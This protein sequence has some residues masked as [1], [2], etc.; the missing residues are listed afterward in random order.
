[1]PR[2]TQ[3]E[4]TRRR[5][6][7]AK[8]KPASF[9][10]ATKRNGKACK[11]EAG[12]GTDHVGR[13]RCKHHTGSTNVGRRV[14]KQLELVDMATPIKNITPG[15]AIHGVLALAAGQL[16]YAT[17]KVAGLDE[18]E[19]VAMGAF[20]PYKNIWL[21]IQRTCMH[22]LA[23]YAKKAADM[24]LAERQGALAEAQTELVGKMLEAVVQELDLSPKQ[25]K[26]LG[27]AL[28]RAQLT[29]VEG[30]KAA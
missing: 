16:A 23:D 18:D 17:Q 27:P 14:A 24:G 2:S 7:E 30:G 13:G 20:G 12:W 8:Q 21:D 26:A 19:L 3:R 1:M 10:G 22:D 9:C 5:K 6:Q 4:R 15:V 25:Q 29:V 28:R 11:R